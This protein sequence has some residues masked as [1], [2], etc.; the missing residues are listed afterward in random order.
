MAFGGSCGVGDVVD[1][2]KGNGRCDRP[3]TDTISAGNAVAAYLASEDA[4]GDADLVHET[5]REIAYR[6]GV[7]DRLA[8]G[9]DRVHDELGVENWTVEGM[10]FSAHDDRA[11]NG[12]GLGLAVA[13]RGADHMY[14]T[15]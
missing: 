13:N 15:L 6:E 8:E 7:G 3:G 5:T 2:M 10:S 14:A 4:F 11:L 12:Q 1:V 9:I